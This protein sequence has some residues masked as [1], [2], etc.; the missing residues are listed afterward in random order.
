MTQGSLTTLTRE[1][2]VHLQ[3]PSTGNQTVLCLPAD[4]TAQED[5]LGRMPQASQPLD[6]QHLTGLQ[7]YI[8]AHVPHTKYSSNVVLH[9]NVG[10][11]GREN[12]PQPHVK[13]RILGVIGGVV[14]VKIGP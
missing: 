14:V 10:G 13:W 4:K 6:A 7:T 9:V 3:P 8:L 12:K 5:G 1:N 11:G 2:P